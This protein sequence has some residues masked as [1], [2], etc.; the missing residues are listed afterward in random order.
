ME[1]FYEWVRLVVAV[2]TNGGIN[3]VATLCNDPNVRNQRSGKY[4]SVL[5]IWMEVGHKAFPFFLKRSENA[6]AQEERS[7]FLG[8]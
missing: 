5:S 1:E 8:L 2:Y 7:F 6:S 3:G 4:S